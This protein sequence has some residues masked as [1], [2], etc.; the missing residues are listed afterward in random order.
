MLVSFCY[1]KVC[2]LNSLLWMSFVVVRRNF[3]KWACCKFNCWRY[4]YYPSGPWLPVL[5]GNL[6]YLYGYLFF[7][8]AATDP[9]GLRPPPCWGFNITHWYFTLTRTPLEEGSALR[10]D[11]YLT[12]HSIHKRHISVPQA[13][14]E[15]VI[16]ASGWQQK[17]YTRII[18]WPFGRNC[19]SSLSK[20]SIIGD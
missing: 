3:E 1:V 17:G 13:R 2:F 11:L 12:T 15:P 9:L 14:F 4:L 20:K 18:K 10:R 16:P 6:H 7:V 5:A 19:S 8:C